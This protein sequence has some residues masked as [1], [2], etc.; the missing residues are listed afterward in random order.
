MTRDGGRR[1]GTNGTRV[2]TRSEPR[3]R[4]ALARAALFWEALWP[5]L[6]VPVALLALFAAL[7]FLNVPAVLPGWL[8]GLALAAFLGGIGY[9]LYRGVRGLRVPDPLAARRRLER[10][11]GLLHRP[12]QV[13]NDRLPADADPET[14]ALWQAH[15]A[16][17][18]RQ[19]ANLRVTPPRPDVARRDPFG[20]RAAAA[21]FLVLGVVVAWGDWDNRLRAAFSPNIAGAAVSGPPVLDIWVNPP[22]YTRLPPQLLRPGQ[23]PAQPQQAA[24]PVGQDRGGQ[25]RGGGHDKTPAQPPVSIPAGSGLLARVAGGTKPPELTA[26]GQQ[27]P[28]TRTDGTNYH[29]EAKVTEG[30][31]IAVT[32]NGRVLGSWP[33]TVV[34]DNPPTVALTDRPKRTERGTLRIDYEAADDYGLVEVKAAIRL[35]QPPE[36]VANAPVELPLPVSGTRPVHAK[37]SGYHD[38]SAHPW[39]GLPVA[40]VLTAS[41]AAGQTGR[42]E[43]TVFELPAREFTHP[44]AQAIIEQRRTLALRGEPAREEVARTLSSISARPRTYGEDLVVFLGLRTTVA[45][46]AMSREPDTI[47]TVQSLLWELALRIEE[48]RL[49]TVERDLRAA[50]RAL[51]EALD[52]N[53]SEEEIRR[54]MDELQRAMDR[55]FQAMEQ[56]LREMLERGETPPMMP[57][58]PNAQTL[59]QQDLQRM[60]DQMRQMAESGSR[61]AARQ[62]LSR[63]QQMMENMRMGMMQQPQASEAGRMMQD[64]QRLIQEQQR[65]MDQT[66]RQSQQ[67]QRGQQGRQ[68]QGQRQP[69]QQG[70]QGQPGGEPQGAQPGNGQAGDMAAMQERLRRELGELMRRM[71]EMNGDIPGGLGR[72]ERAMRGAEQALGEGQPGQALP[73]QSTALDELQ[74]GLQNFAE[75]MGQQGGQQA[76]GD[77]DGQ[78][79]QQFGRPNPR[80]GRDPLGRNLQGTGTSSGEDVRI[81]AEADLQRA[82]EILDELR[83]RAGETTRPQIERDYIERLLRRFGP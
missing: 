58:D 82:R 53:A 49:S 8:H 44:V 68:G 30:D 55:F 24:A 80:N 64:M 12:L 70:Q 5:A 21:L 41:D 78:A 31:R 50:Q 73:Q 33:I 34:A 43:E 76:G 40:M 17:A 18:R 9:A 19:L 45:R 1:S 83:R 74:Q 7:A 16:H 2:E 27:T 57:Y 69:G 47:A 26:N 23:G 35:H 65:L 66:F 42:S 51:A 81:P 56:Q 6:W 36:G 37:H 79:Q 29:V 61:D 46:L 22:E 52:R 14:V 62:M 32:Q 15:Q 71:G 67:Q 3:L 25:D 20:L 48:G 11:S 38:L 60:M 59:S 28:F 77:Q 75:Q 54:L 10:D 63:L 13:V 39:A 72:A 4:L